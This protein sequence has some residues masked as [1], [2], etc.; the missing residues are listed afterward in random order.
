MQQQQVNIDISQA[1]DMGCEKCGHLYFAPVAMMKKLSALLSP[2]G[3]ELK[4]PV[5]CF[6][7]TKCGHVLEPTA[8]G[9][10]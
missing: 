5:Q 6:Q 9:S 1:E 7:C 3:Q 4:F 10:Q 2:T 8:P